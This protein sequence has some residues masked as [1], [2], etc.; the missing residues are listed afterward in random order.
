MEVARQFYHLCDHTR[1]LERNG[2]TGD[3]ASYPPLKE[4]LRRT[5]EA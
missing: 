3:T 5:R 4:R 1:E 2:R